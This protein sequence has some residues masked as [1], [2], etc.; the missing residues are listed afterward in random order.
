[1]FHIKKG[2]ARVLSTRQCLLL[3]GKQ[4]ENMGPPEGLFSER[5]G[6]KAHIILHLHQSNVYVARFKQSRCFTHIITL[7]FFG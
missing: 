6:G 5:R 2:E 3:E 4:V 1:M 7:I